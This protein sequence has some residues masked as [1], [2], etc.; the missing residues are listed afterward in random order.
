[1]YEFIKI[2]VLIVV[3]RYLSSLR[4]LCTRQAKLRV[5]PV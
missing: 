1:M 2:W 3:I 4:E 5:R